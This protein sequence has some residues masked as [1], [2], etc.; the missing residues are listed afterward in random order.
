MSVGCYYKFMNIYNIL[1]KKLG[2]F[3]IVVRYKYAKLYYL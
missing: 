1:N 3:E 2:D